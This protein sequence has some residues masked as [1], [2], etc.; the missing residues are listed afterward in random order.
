M[1]PTL[2][3]LG[4]D[5]A[6]LKGGDKLAKRLAAMGKA[7][8]SAKK[9][10]AGFPKGG[11]YP[12]GTSVPM[13]AAIQE[14]GAPKVGIP[15]RPFMRTTF[16]A[17][18]QKWAG[19]LAAL[20]A[21]RNYDA[22]SALTAVGEVMQGDI[23][24]GIASVSSPPLSPVTADDR[25]YYRWTPDALTITAVPLVDATMTGRD[26]NSFCSALSERN[27]NSYRVTR[28]LTHLFDQMTYIQMNLTVY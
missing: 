24:E 20:I 22:R 8:N 10:Q 11:T 5:M 16:A 21:E 26:W 28:L 12:D 13:V 19:N 27:P 25:Q 14:F 4:T 6:A 23:K 15:P 18:N 3:N 17:E 9:V 1:S 7:L 2:T